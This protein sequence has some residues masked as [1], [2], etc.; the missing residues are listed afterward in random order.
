MQ[1]ASFG[2]WTWVADYMFHDNN[3]NTTSTYWE[4]N[5]GTSGDVM[6]S[7]PDKRT[8][9]SEFESHWVP[10]S[11]GHVPRLSK[12]LSKLLLI[13]KRFCFYVCREIW[14]TSKFYECQFLFLH[15][16]GEVL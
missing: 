1:E 14:A 6:V 10:H 13:K 3:D 4:R 7:K 5:V 15:I 16:K 11:Y 12:E 2:I 8:Y 9:T